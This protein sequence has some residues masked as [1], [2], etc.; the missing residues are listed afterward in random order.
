MKRSCKA[1]KQS[2][3]II[4]KLAIDWDVYLRSSA[5]DIDALWKKFL[6]KYREAEATCIPKKLVKFGKR[7]FKYALDKKH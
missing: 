7:R 6:E 5:D 1:R 4:N 3:T 2:S